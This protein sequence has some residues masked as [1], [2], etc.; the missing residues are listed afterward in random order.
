MRKFPFWSIFKQVLVSF[1][2]NNGLI[3]AG[4]VAYMSLLS[5][6][7]LFV[8]LVSVLS[9]FFPTEL[10]LP[11]IGD[12]LR[13]LV[14]SYAGL[15][16]KEITV[17]LK[18][19]QL[20][21]GVGLI[22]LLVFSSFAFTFMQRSMNQI[23]E[24]RKEQQDLKPRSFWISILMPYM[25]IA[26]IGLGLFV[27]TITHIVLDTLASRSFYL[28]GWKLS[29]AGFSGILIYLLSVFGMVIMFSS[30]YI[31]MPQGRVE[32]RRAIAG[33]LIA[34][35]LWEITR[36]VLVW[37]FNSLSLVNVVYGSL[38]TVIVV[39]LFFEVGA[40]ILLLGAQIIAELE[41]TSE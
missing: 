2:A 26:V 8:I 11:A 41:K 30:I 31:V 9:L 23:F 32:Y 39:L 20:F 21:G 38:T 17:A 22:T 10:L 18:Q 7:P 1:Q 4:A 6:I 28:F 36:N 24:H 15:L 27:L 12:Y 34:A 14:P 29:L 25:Y 37:Y 3:L 5:I 19:R 40:I 16:M 13:L 35:L 33:G